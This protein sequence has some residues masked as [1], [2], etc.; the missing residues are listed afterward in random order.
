MSK[1]FEVLTDMQLL[2]KVPA[3]NPCDI[4]GQLAGYYVTGY[5]IHVCGDEC[6]NAFVTQVNK[7]IN[8]FATEQL[9]GVRLD[10]SD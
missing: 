3:D 9:K 6:F 1:F 8:S 10:G 5:Y 7:E 2:S 4:C